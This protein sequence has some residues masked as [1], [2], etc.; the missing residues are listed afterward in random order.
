MLAPLAPVL[1]VDPVDPP[2]GSV[3]INRTIKEW[4]VAMPGPEGS[5]E[6]LGTPLV[7]STGIS[8]QFRVSE[9][10]GLVFIMGLSFAVGF[11][12]PVVVLLLGWVGLVDRKFLAR[13]RKYALF[14]C[15]IAA[16]ILTPSPDPFSMIILAAPLYMLYELGMILLRVL[17]AG[18]VARGFTWAGK[19]YGV[20]QEP[21]AGEP[22]TA[23]DE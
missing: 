11:Q 6:I 4:R 18:R 14:I 23:G 13:N 22:P 3:W 21:A 2:L 9:Y 16:A 15:A 20:S 7:Q 1:E 19:R 8:Q 17:P 10:I 5:I 12:T